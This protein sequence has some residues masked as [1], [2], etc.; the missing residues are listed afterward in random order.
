M[1]ATRFLLSAFAV[2]IAAWSSAQSCDFELSGR[3]IDEHDMQPLAYAEVFITSLG[4][5]AVT[6]D[7][8]HYRI[9][10][11]CPGTYQVRVHHLGCEPVTREVRLTSSTTIDFKL[12][13][14][15]EELR[16]LEVIQARPDEQVGQPAKSVD[17]EDME[18]AAGT[19]IADLL[20]R[21]P[22][23]TVLATGPSIG[24]PVIHG[25]SGNRVLILN[26]GIR[27]E[28]Q[29]WGS[30]HAP[31][32]DPLSADRITVVK[33]AASVQYG[34]DAIGGAVIVEP[35]ELPRTAG[36]SGELRGL[37]QW[38]GRGGGGSGLLEGGVKG[39]TG[40]GWRVQ[41]SGRYLG[42][43]EA[44]RYTLSNTGQREWSGSAS[45]GYRD[46]RRGASVFYSRFTREL[47]IL[48]AAHIG[49][50][51]DLQ[52]A[53]ESGEPWYTAPF[54]Y[55]I[56]APRQTVT[57]H[58]LRVQGSIA[59]TDRNRLEVNYG[60]Q[61]ND[62]QEYDIRRAGRSATPALDLWLATHTAEAVLK[63]WIGEHVHGKVGVTALAQENTNIP[64]TGVRPLIPDFRKESI[65]AFI[66]EHMPV[67]ERLELEAGARAEGTLL[68]VRRFDREGQLQAPEHRFTNAAFAL[69]A[70]YQLSDSARLRL[71]LASAFRPP[72]V[73]ELYSEGLHHSAAAI[74]EGDALLGSERSLKAT[75]DAE[76]ALFGGRLRIDATVHA[77]RIKGFIY[78]RPDGTRLT[79]RGAF[80]VFRY[81]ATDALMGGLDAS[82]TLKLSKRF[83]WRMRGSTV[84]ARDQRRDEWL[85]LMP[86]DR[87]EN[88][89]L[90]RTASGGKWRAFEAGATH[91]AVFE[92]RRIPEGL[93][94]APPPSTYH[95]FALS[96]SA[97][98]T[99]GKGE[100]RIGLQ[101]NNLFNTAYR[102]YL[103]RFRYFTDARGTDIVLSVRYAF[104]RFAEKRL[105]D[106]G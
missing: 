98:R 101:A 64:G 75:L 38:N 100:L 63:H 51:T 106:A 55:A 4:K 34:S 49:S 6:N 58:L 5:G 86:A 21:V 60:Y 81:T 82:A 17:R 92:Q 85:F 42:D 11:L 62:R 99:L 93:D 53:I 105:H 48:R 40:L 91:Q 79:I 15:A 96:A 70:S 20:A 25:L 19:G 84:H 45:V 9:E 3:V 89:L 36:I 35:V 8:G 7:Q 1:Q 90:F 29:Q 46:H 16:E 83:A 57:H 30:E 77:S 80:P 102:D 73:S 22:G 31:S 61:A 2:V 44:A 52:R 104:G 28:D 74:E 18:R 39:I 68:H 88:G 71:G 41:G 72:H 43:S 24:K 69:G 67:G 94:F 33:G 32:L 97:S 78:L 76:A 27:Q 56:D 23:V 54:S 65:G 14:H 50:T 12:E 66:I 13:H 87:L 37:G 47:G 95:L 59:L 26:Q 103:D 10:G